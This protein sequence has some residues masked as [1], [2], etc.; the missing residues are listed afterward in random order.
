MWLTHAL[1]TVRPLRLIDFNM[2]QLLFQHPLLLIFS[3]CDDCYVF[4]AVFPI[5]QAGNT[6]AACRIF[7]LEYLHLTSS[8]NYFLIQFL[9]VFCSSLVVSSYLSKSSRHSLPQVIWTLTYSNTTIIMN[10]SFFSVSSAP[11]QF[12]VNTSQ[13]NP[14]QNISG[15][16]LPILGSNKV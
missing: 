14:T 2:Y 15:F 11:N 12:A 7:C 3:T 5:S 13:L 10:L 1:L 8:R 6:Q 9:S 4:L 16:L